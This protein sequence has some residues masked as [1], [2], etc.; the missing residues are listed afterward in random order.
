MVWPRTVL[1]WVGLVFAAWLPGA[2]WAETP[3]AGDRPPG[4]QGLIE[5]SGKASDG[6]RLRT[7]PTQ[8]RAHRA[9]HAR[10]I[11]RT[12]DAVITYYAAGGRAA[13]DGERSPLTDPR[14]RGFNLSTAE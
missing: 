4:A 1:W 3:A 10:R 7:I 14:I 13:I 6:G 2:A 9:L 12:L 8:R 5:H 11:D